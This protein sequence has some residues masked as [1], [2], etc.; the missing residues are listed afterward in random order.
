MNKSQTRATYAFICTIVFT[1]CSAVL[2][3]LGTLPTSWKWI[4]T[5]VSTLIAISSSLITLFNQSLSSEHVSIPVGEAI[6][7][8]LVKRPG[9]PFDGPSETS[10]KG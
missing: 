8:G 3:Q 6:D 7:A 5:L 2:P 4:A 9:F 10:T 1:V